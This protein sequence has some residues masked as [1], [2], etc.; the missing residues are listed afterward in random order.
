[1]ESIAATIKSNEIVLP[2][3]AVTHKCCTCG[4]Y[5]HKTR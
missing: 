3:N 2:V 5:S 1:M 4:S